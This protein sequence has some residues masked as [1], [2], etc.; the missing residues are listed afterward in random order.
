MGSNI[1]IKKLCEFCNTEYVAK[2]TVTR[3][4][5]T[6][7][8]KVHWKQLQRQKKIQKSTRFQRVSDQEKYE[9]TRI[10][11]FLNIKECAELI[12]VSERTLN[13][14][15]KTDILISTKIG[16]RRIIKKS[17]LNQLF[18]TLKT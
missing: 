10:K 1:R 14:L 15:I 3:Y 7:C 18:N 17:D 11:E 5:S 2:T 16:S 12:G 8:Y 6:K 4:C 13:R 9:F